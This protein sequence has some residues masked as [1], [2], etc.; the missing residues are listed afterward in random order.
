MR[1]WFEKFAARRMD[2]AQRIVAPAE[3]WEPFAD[4]GRPERPGPLIERRIVGILSAIAIPLAILFWIML[5]QPFAENGP[6]YVVY[7]LHDQMFLP[8][9]GR[10]WTEPYPRS[11]FG[12]I[13][14]A[15]VIVALLALRGRISGLHAGLASRYLHTKLGR[16]SAIAWATGLP[17]PIVN[18]Y[19]RTIADFNVDASLERVA[20]GT[21]EAEA[22]A[23]A[24]ELAIWLRRPAIRRGD[25]R[26]AYV[27]AEILLKAA[28]ALTGD[29]RISKAS[30]DL[31]QTITA[32]GNSLGSNFD[33]APIDDTLWLV[34]H[35]A[36]AR[37]PWSPA[38]RRDPKTIDFVVRAQARA[39][40]LLTAAEQGQDGRK[41]WPDSG[42][43]ARRLSA[44]AALI[45]DDRAVFVRWWEAEK[46][47]R[48]VADMAAAANGIVV[49]SDWDLNLANASDVG[50]IQ[51][52][53]R[54]RVKDGQPDTVI[55]TGLDLAF[56]A[57][58]VAKIVDDFKPRDP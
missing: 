21:P 17:F 56:P 12:V 20:R 57:D 37:S 8:A 14:V 16:V 4:A 11:L 52:F 50:A 25:G 55:Y 35:K 43:L 9:K 15:V 44:K 6:A 49:A 24:V 26:A 46:R 58:W 18:T 34:T 23:G 2:T 7:W 13:V 42:S 31:A 3:G 32:A 45:S 30:R 10:L 48:F 29:K 27:A 5:A 19:L 1:H 53:A 54:N 36:V 39:D 33:R 51:N 41:T 28:E 40:V 22:D 38:E 47:S